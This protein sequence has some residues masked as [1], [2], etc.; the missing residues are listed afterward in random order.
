M[1]TAPRGLVTGDSAAESLLGEAVS[2]LLVLWPP[3][4]W[5]PLA[6]TYLG[7]A[8]D[9]PSPNFILE[10]TACLVYLSLSFLHLKVTSADSVCGSSVSS[11]IQMAWFGD[12]LRIDSKPYSTR[13]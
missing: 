4:A 5:G 13:V 6:S 11:S 10:V 3:P 8:V 12:N 1:T 9:G 7:L 2:A